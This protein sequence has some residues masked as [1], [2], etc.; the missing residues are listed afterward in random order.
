MHTCIY[1][2][3]HVCSTQHNR[4]RTRTTRQHATQHSITST[5]QR[6][7][8]QPARSLPIS[9]T[10][11]HTNTPPPHHPFSLL[12]RHARRQR[13]GATHLYMSVSMPRK[14]PRRRIT[15]TTSV[16]FQLN[17]L[18]SRPPSL[19]ALLGRTA[20]GHAERVWGR[21]KRE[22]E[23]QRERDRER[24][25]DREAERD[26]DRDREAERGRDRHRKRRH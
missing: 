7:T 10:S 6:N 1:A 9:Q 13:P 11:T 2:R 23:R 14:G 26:R 12:F 19:S 18:C 20:S 3:M 16:S 24:Q 17:P 15:T 25:R 4:P 21:R 5:Q 8:T 22:E